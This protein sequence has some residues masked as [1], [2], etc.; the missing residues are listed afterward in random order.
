[1][2]KTKNF[3]IAH[4]TSLSFAAALVLGIG[5]ACFQLAAGESFLELIFYGMIL[6]IFLIHPLILTVLNMWFLVI[7][8]MNPVVC[9]KEQQ[10]Q[11]LTLGLGLLY[12]LF[13]F[14][15]A[16]I[17]IADW[18]QRLS[19]LQVHTPVWTE[20]FLTVGVI[21]AVGVCGYIFLSVRP[22]KKM[23]PL[24][25]VCAM[26]ACYLGIGVSILWIVQIFSPDDLIM[27]YLC[28]LPL[29]WIILNIKLIRKKVREWKD[30]PDRKSHIFSNPVLNALNK[31]LENA[32]RW[33]VTAF[34]F[35][36]PLLG[37][38]ICILVLFGQEPDYMIEGWTKTS[39]WNLSAQTAPPNVY[40]D[41]HYLCTVAAGG[42]R[43]LV[44]PLRMG[45]RHGHPVV[46]NRQLCIANAFEEILE[47]KLPRIHRCVRD[48]YDTWGFPLARHI[49]SPY[50]ADL[51]YLM[52]KA[53]EWWFLGV[54]YFCD[55][56]PENRIAVQYMPR[57]KEKE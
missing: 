21:L 28:L 4:L 3:I 9:Q 43:R 54:I 24:M 25:T 27:E 50:K 37:I 56:K 46:V 48:F 19:N 42:H 57:E 22:I 35:M 15:V 17:Q 41:E 53:L 11:Y 30:L 29:N 8:E 34:V 38:L 16:N 2:K 5:G 31:R 45:E 33:P 10:I 1:M 52:M 20:A 14:P 12:S 36:W 40:Y 13:L 49:R 32:S 39:D 51:V 47:E 55:I 18:D 26:A 7:K 23:P 44:K 6:G